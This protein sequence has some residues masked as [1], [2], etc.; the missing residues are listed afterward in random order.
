MST[1]SLARIMYG[2]NQEPVMSGG[3]NSGAPHPLSPL[4]SNFASAAPESWTNKIIA[5]FLTTVSPPRS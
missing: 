2:S 4:S 3:M 1:L 5:A